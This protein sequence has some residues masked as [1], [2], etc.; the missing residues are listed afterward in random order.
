[1]TRLVRFLAWTVP[2]LAGLAILA[3]QSSQG[4]SPWLINESS[5]LPP[6]LYR[7][8]PDAP[9][10]RGAIVAIAEPPIGRSYLE[11]LGRPAT[12]GLLKRIAATSGETVCAHADGIHVG[13]DHVPVRASDGRGTALPRWQG[14]RR[15]GPGELFL[16]GDTPGSFDSRYFGPV[17]IETVEG[18]YREVLLW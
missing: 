14:C 12:T 7:H 3:T 2:P 4:P 8:R 5:S 10:S 15:L 13:A 6:G 9:L 11:S 16:L 1:M 17:R 18:P